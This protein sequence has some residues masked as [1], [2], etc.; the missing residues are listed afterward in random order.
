M[1]LATLASGSSGNSSVVTGGQTSLLIDAGLSGKG[2]STR[3]ES[4]GVDVKKLAGILVTHEHQDH[5]QG[6]GVL[7]RR[8]KLPVYALEPCFAAMEVGVLPDGC[9][10]VLEQ[11]EALEIGELKVELFN[12][13]HDSM[14]ST[15]FVCF[16]AESKIGYATDTGEVSPIM[17]RKLRGSNAMIFE[18]NHDEE[19]LWR[20]R[21]PYHLKQRIAAS[22]GHLSNTDAGKALAEIIDHKTKRIILAHLSEENNLPDIALHTVGNI[23]HEAGVPALAPELK[24]RTA[25]RHMPLGVEDV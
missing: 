3:L 24:I 12:T 11:G 18:S 22:T 15:G 20:G 8:H 6:V 14:A 7:A 10:H 2:I 17:I 25:P 23:L 16:H 1:K 21:Y 13:S 19:M 9:C 4:L 5:I